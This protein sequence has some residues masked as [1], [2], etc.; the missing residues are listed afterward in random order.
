MT[1]LLVNGETMHAFTILCNVWKLHKEKQNITR[2]YD[3]I[4]FETRDEHFEQLYA[5]LNDHIASK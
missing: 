2:F 5:E 1:I 3:L 4:T